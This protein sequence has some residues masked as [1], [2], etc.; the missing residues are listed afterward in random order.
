[1]RRRF[2]AHVD[3]LDSVFVD[4]YIE[5]TGAPFKCMLV[6]AHKCDVLAADL[7]ALWK[8][9]VLKRSPAGCSGVGMG[10][11]KWIWSYS[12]VNP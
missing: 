12:L 2:S 6:G 7:R 3:T 4:A 5:Y 9:G 1:M 10:F 8:Q 11:P